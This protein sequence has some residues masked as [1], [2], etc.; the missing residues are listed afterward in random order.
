MSDAL[1]DRMKMYEMAEAGRKAMPKLPILL[2]ADGKAFH[3]FTS[4]M[5][6][7][8]EEPYHKGLSDLMIHTMLKAVEFT[9]A[10][11]GYTQ[12]DEISLIILP[13]EREEAI[14]G[15]RFQKLTSIVA[16]KISVEF[17]KAMSSFGV[18]GKGT[19]LFD[20]R[21]W[22]VPN[23][24]EAVNAVLWREQDAMKNSIQ[25][26]ARTLFSHAEVQD[27]NS[28]QLQEMMFQKGINWNDYPAFFKRGT[29]GRRVFVYGTFSKEELED[30]PPKHRAHT[31]PN[32]TF[33]RSQIQQVTFP[34]L[35]RV[36]NKVDVLLNGMPP[37]TAAEAHGESKPSEAEAVNPDEAPFEA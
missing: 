18:E 36:V 20:C 29:Y 26:A 10:R 17:A 35:S 14:F 3:S 6:R 2:R 30:L 4:R 9:N 8:P 24:M 34:V 32:L 16:A 1:G 5:K 7:T 25:M 33:E 21:A 27:K 19:P 37:V 11:V 15:G 31:D 22:N 28:K 23:E 13:R 12:S